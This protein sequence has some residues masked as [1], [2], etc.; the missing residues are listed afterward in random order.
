MC[1]AQVEFVGYGE[2]QRPDALSDVARIERTPAG[3]Q[4]T[5]LVGHV[6]QLEAEIRSIDFMES[7]VHL[8]RRETSPADQ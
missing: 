8:E 3:L 6:T 2:E 7:V 4:V 1:L 5:D